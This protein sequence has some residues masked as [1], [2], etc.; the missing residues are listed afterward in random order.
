MGQALRRV[1]GRLRNSSFEP[2]STAPQKKNVEW[3]PP[4]PPA[5]PPP[6]DISTAGQ[7]H[8]G[9]S[10]PES[11]ST[12]KNDN[13]LEE[14]DPGYDA[15][16]SQLVGRIRSKPGGQPEMGDTMVA[17]RYSR[18]MPKLRTTKAEASDEQKAVPPGTLD[19]NQLRHIFLLH[20]GKA[21]DHHGPM[22]AHGIAEKFRLDVV[23]IE[24]ILQHA[25][26]PPEESTK[27]QNDESS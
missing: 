13:V 26:L 17:E 4:P 2:P 6:P 10:N 18:P 8:L 7:D 27:K 25:S 3:R 12:V 22:D 1:G 5:P 19:I 9:V 16:L 15:M 14:R 20:Q 11:K 24:K 21:D 23:Q